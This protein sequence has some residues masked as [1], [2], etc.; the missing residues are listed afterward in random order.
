MHAQANQY[1]LSLHP[2]EAKMTYSMHYTADGRDGMSRL[3][4]AR[5]GLLEGFD[6]NR[7]GLAGTW[8]SFTAALNVTVDDNGD[9]EAKGWSG[10]RKTGRA[11]AN[12]T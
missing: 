10:T 4:R 8:L 9:L 12:T 1:P 6:E 2:G 5:I 11:A 3:Q 7:K